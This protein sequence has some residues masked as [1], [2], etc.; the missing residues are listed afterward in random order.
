MAIVNVAGV[1]QHISFASDMVE[2]YSVMKMEN[3]FIMMYSNAENLS[4]I[5]IKKEYH[6]SKYLAMFSIELYI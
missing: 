5:I 6:R 2:K 4:F 3:L 1:L